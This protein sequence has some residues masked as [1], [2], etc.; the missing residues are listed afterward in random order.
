MAVCIVLSHLTLCEP[1]LP[2]PLCIEVP[3]LIPKIFSYVIIKTQMSWSL[4]LN[5]PKK[6]ISLTLTLHCMELSCHKFQP[7]RC[8]EETGVVVYGVDN[9][10]CFILF[11]TCCHV[12]PGSLPVNRGRAAH[13]S[14]CLFLQLPDN[15]TA[16][17][18][19]L[20]HLSLQPSP[21]PRWGFSKDCS[22][23]RMIAE[24]FSCEY[25]KILAPP[26][27]PSPV[28][29]D[30]MWIP[31]HHSI[32]LYLLSPHRTRFDLL[33]LFAAVVD[34]EQC[35]CFYLYCSFWVCNNI[36]HCLFYQ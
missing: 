20:Q 27:L 12:I 5:I 2:E 34:W 21:W 14:T 10:I 18:P 11:N 25:Y 29:L 15:C 17:L 16:L 31:G 24:L 23:L 3:G 1:F 9:S 33:L 28:I 19:L 35:V 8:L 30:L 7:S 32:L 36:H 13:R 26:L 6:Y 4:C 22:G